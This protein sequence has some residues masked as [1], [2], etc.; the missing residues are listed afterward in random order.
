[1]LVIYPAY[2]SQERTVTFLDI[3]IPSLLE[4][5]HSA[6]QLIAANSLETRSVAASP[7]GCRV[8]RTLGK[9]HSHCATGISLFSI[10]H[11][12]AIPCSS[13]FFPIFL[14][15]SSPFLWLSKHTLC[16]TVVNLSCMLYFSLFQ[17]RSIWES[18]LWNYGFKS[19]LSNISDL[20]KTCLLCTI[21]LM[22][23]N[24]LDVSSI[25]VHY[26]CVNIVS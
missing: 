17:K 22:C 5:I 11:L 15:F 23:V 9:E 21:P 20:C 6:L 26:S 2:I 18:V 14:L 8:R 19:L 16:I 1:M 7:T 13:L 4:S 12:L 3:Q 24:L 10:I 25:G